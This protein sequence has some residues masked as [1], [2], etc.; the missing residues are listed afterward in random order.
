MPYRV[1]PDS[2]EG[3]VKSM[4][5]VEDRLKLVSSD[6]VDTIGQLA[7]GFIQDIF[8]KGKNRNTFFPKGSHSPTNR[9]TPLY[10]GW[11]TYPTSTNGSIGFLLKHA[12]MGQSHI[13]TIL[14]SL[15]QGSRAYD[16]QL[17]N[18]QAFRFLSLKN[19][20]LL[21]ASSK[22][23]YKTM[24]IPARRPN[25]SPDGYIS[26]TKQFIT[27]MMEFFSQQA[28]QDLEKSFEQK[29]LRFSNIKSSVLAGKISRIT[30][31]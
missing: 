5:A 31:P 2:F 8:P 30:T 18:A 20:V 11:T 26:P 29:A 10:S 7:K 13:A 4:R 15:D 1:T 27:D 6:D 14:A 3:F 12:R 17:K 9:G 25:P 22:G 28:A 24:R 21:R 16:I 19:D 23:E